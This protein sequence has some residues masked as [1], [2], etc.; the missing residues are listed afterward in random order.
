MEQRSGLWTGGKGADV[1]AQS[2]P[3]PVN[4]LSATLHP[5]RLR[6]SVLGVG[7]VAFD[8]GVVRL[9][10]ALLP[11]HAYIFFLCTTA[12]CK[13]SFTLAL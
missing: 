12:S 5:D 13:T 2:L 9:H 11:V 10:P 6:A 7:L 4:D 1:L 8:L 3:T